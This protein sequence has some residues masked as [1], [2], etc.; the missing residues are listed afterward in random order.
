[1]ASELREVWRIRCPHLQDKIIVSA[2]YAESERARLDAG[3]W[4]PTLER[5]PLLMPE[6]A[7]VL[8]R[9][10]KLQDLAD[11]T[12]VDMEDDLFAASWGSFSRAVLAYI[13]ARGTSH[14]TGQ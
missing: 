8:D 5:L 11:A 10:C 3:G 4:N 2:E 1:M 14:D 9:A 12:G 13:E 7:A 6:A